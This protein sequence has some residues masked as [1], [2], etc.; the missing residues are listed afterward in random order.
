VVVG[1]GAEKFALCNTLLV[2]RA[3]GV[4]LDVF[5]LAVLKHVDG[6]STGAG[7]RETFFGEEGCHGVKEFVNIAVNV[8]STEEGDVV[9][10]DKLNLRSVPGKVKLGQNV[11]KVGT[12]NGTA[13]NS[14]EASISAGSGVVHE[15]FG[16]SEDTSGE[17]GHVFV[18]LEKGILTAGANPWLHADSLTLGTDID[19]SLFN[20]PLV[21][22][23]S[24]KSLVLRA[25]FSVTGLVPGGGEECVGSLELV[26]GAENGSVNTCCN[27]S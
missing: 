16:D 15:T 4:F 1:N 19:M 17:T 10:E 12:S 27:S 2:G 25:V 8:E 5:V 18:G 21:I 24:F 23:G 20:H 11:E 14:V 26:N 3:Q 7:G 22:I 13:L 9:L 6:G